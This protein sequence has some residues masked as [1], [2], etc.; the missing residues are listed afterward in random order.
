MRNKSRGAGYTGTESEGQRRLGWERQGGLKGRRKGE[1][2][3][4]WA[5]QR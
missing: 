5:A 3:R 4:E 2:L 1:K